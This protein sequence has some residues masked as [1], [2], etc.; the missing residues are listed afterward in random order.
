[1]N[2]KLRSTLILLVFLILILAVSIGYYSFVLGKELKEKSAKLNELSSKIIDEAELSLR[3]ENLKRKSAE[4]D[5]I[6]ANKRFFV[7]SDLTPTYFFEFSNKVA[8][9]FSSESQINVEY[10]QQ[11]SEGEF[12]THNYKVSGFGLFNEVFG[13][14]QAVEKS[15]SLK[16][17]KSLSL[18]TIVNV[19]KRGVP[20][21]HTNFDVEVKSYFTADKNFAP[22]QPI[23]DSMNK[24]DLYNFLYPLIR[25]EIPPNI[26]DLLDVQDARLLALLPDGAFISDNKGNTYLLS[27]GEEVYLGYLTKIDYNNNMV[28]FVL[29]KGGIIEKINLFLE[30]SEISKNKKE[31]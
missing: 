5:S 29:N 21:Y 15:K 12:Q 13:F 16:K 6:L 1:M 30:T 10:L 8:R 23:P 31:K 18:G 7:Y 25:T 24:K 9:S 4:I 22:S 19:D 3:L 20:V 28:S 14:L 27:E 26:Y 11:T 17:I 2:K